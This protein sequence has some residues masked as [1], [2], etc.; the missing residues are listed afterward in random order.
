M[1][2]RDGGSVGGPL[3]ADCAAGAKTDNKKKREKLVPATF[4]FIVFT[5]QRAPNGTL[6]SYSELGRCLGTHRANYGRFIGINKDEVRPRP[7][8][9]LD[10]AV[11]LNS[12]MRSRKRRKVSARFEQGESRGEIVTIMYVVA[13][14]LAGGIGWGVL[15]LLLEGI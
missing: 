6:R 1:D 8:K 10:F 12:L 5:P 3:A 14:A 11:T 4:A 13:T 7:A 2:R 15:G 9:S